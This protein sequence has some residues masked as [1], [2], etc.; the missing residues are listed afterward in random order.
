MIGCFGVAGAFAFS[1]AGIGAGVFACGLIA[2]G[3]L[4]L[5]GMLFASELY[6]LGKWAE[7]AEPIASESPVVRVLAAKSRKAESP[8]V[9][10]E[11]QRLY[12]QKIA[13]M[14]EEVAACRKEV[15]VRR[16]EIVRARREHA[17]RAAKELARTVSR[18]VEEAAKGVR[19]VTRLNLE[20]G[21]VQDDVPRRA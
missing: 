2:F 12:A 16:K 8:E 13:A 6:S 9:S 11:L 19:P 15:A 3:F 7:G 18:E 17:E 14:E 21:G 10:A 5:A 4:A 1:T 20:S